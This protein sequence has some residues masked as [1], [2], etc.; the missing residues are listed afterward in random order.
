[1]ATVVSV[2]PNPNQMGVVL[3]SVITI[4]FSTLMDHTTLGQSSFSVAAPSATQILTPDQYISSNPSTLQAIGYVTG[5]YSYD[6]TS[7]STVFTFNPTN[8]LKPNTT[9]QLILLG[10]D[11]T[12]SSDYAKDT[13]G[14]PL[15]SSYQWSFQTGSINLVTPPI[16]SP[17]PPNNPAID[18]K[19][20]K[21]LLNPRGKVV[22]N[23][24]TQ[25]IDIVFPVAINPASFNINDILLS[26]DA[27]I[28]DP[29]VT[30][31]PNLTTTAT[32]DGNRIKIV[33]TGW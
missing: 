11:G 1:M 16:S 31:P 24:L 12:V 13:N 26:L 7:G 5:I 28:G 29:S 15:A 25:E 32:I 17:L 21:V 10:G 22:G 8:P 30:V 18:P 23:D 4:T 6:D 33:I 2:T 14:I 27:V 3:G 9:Y 19:D 20:I